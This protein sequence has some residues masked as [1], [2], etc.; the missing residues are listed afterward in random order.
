MLQIMKTTHLILYRK[1]RRNF[2]EFSII[3]MVFFARLPHSPD[4]SVLILNVVLFNYRPTD[5]RK[6]EIIF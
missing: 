3:A 6:F 2:Y 1:K 4:R 5:H